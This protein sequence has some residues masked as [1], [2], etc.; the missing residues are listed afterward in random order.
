MRH[1]TSGRLVQ[2]SASSHRARVSASSQTAPFRFKLVLTATVFVSTSCAVGCILPRQPPGTEADAL[3]MSA[4]GESPHRVTDGDPG[5]P[6]GEPPGA[7]PP[8][9]PPGCY[10]YCCSYNRSSSRSRPRYPEPGTDPGPTPG[11]SGPVPVPL[12][13]FLWSGSR[14]RSRDT[15]H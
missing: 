14:S 1:L 11:A 9:E 6:P 15:T 12:D 5:D 13:Q 10:C 8:G 4:Q 3:A 2:H 7:S